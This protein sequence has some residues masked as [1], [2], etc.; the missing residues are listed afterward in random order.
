MDSKNANAAAAAPQAKNRL[1][2]LLL[3]AVSPALLPAAGLVA[4]LALMPR[5]GVSVVAAGGLVALGLALASRAGLVIATTAMGLLCAGLAPPSEPRFESW[6]P[7]EVVGVVRSHPA[8]HDERT[9]L[10]VQVSR[11]RQGLSVSG[12]TFDL[13]ASLPL[14]LPAPPIGTTVRLRGY[15]RRSAGY[16]NLV[17][18]DPGPW[19]L[20]LKSERFLSAE[21]PPKG[22]AALAGALRRRAEAVLTEHD[23]GRPGLRLLRAL[24]FGDR[25]ALPKAWQQA[26][27]RSGLA[28]IL[29]VSGLHVGL[30]AAALVLAGALLPDRWRWLPAVLGL[31]VYGLLVGP[32]PAVLRASI[33]GLLM[34][35]ALRCH[36]PPQTLNALAACVAL[37]VLQDPSIV[38]RLG[39]QL[40]VAAT[41]GI[42]LLA[43]ALDRRWVWLPA[44]VRQPL[45]VTVAAQLATAPWILPL[46]GGIQGVA[47]LANLLA[48]PYLV[49]FLA[50]AFVWLGVAS[51]CPSA[52]AT[53][54]PLLDAA[55]QPVAALAALP[56]GYA[57]FLPLGVA[58]PGALFGAAVG[59]TACLW[60]RLAGRC[61]T[62]CW[63]AILT[64]SGDSTQPRL[65]SPEIALIDVGQGDATLLRDGSRAVLVDGGGWRYGDLGGRVVLP[66]LAALGVRQLDAVVATHPD[67]DH[68][69]GLV[70]VARYMPVG[71]VWVGP[72]WVEDRCAAELLTLPRLRWRVLWRGEEERVGRW[73][74]RVLH[75][76]AGQRRARNDRSLV[77]FAELDRY[78]LWLTGDIEASG[79]RQLARDLAADRSRVSPIDRQRGPRVDILKVA[80]HG[81]KTST[82][83]A[84]LRRVRPQLA[85]ISAGPGN[86]YGHPHRRTLRRLEAHGVKVLRTDLSGMVR[87]KLRAS[88][89]AIELP[90]SPRLIA[91]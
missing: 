70:D 40:S 56:P 54:L 3:P 84:F 86:L 11:L 35:A 61:L 55:T 51:V 36:R 15:L 1:A 10:W 23:P 64:G 17:R 8:R 32:R 38:A 50:S 19:R 77:I 90:G 37:M 25:S 66:A 65:P 45:A 78:R 29:A 7:V 83:E 39:F 46:T 12:V 43:P 31:I 82:T 2:R 41:A 89:L 75:P 13:A 44:L 60:P 85:L 47:P 49:V 53:L 73:R 24:V 22:L 14:A 68:C 67:R 4:G 63:L 87:L 16:A 5:G 27:Q 42:L 79:E 28:H 59:L 80:H 91:E 48:V 57:T 33:M 88:H 26:L 58:G 20:Y 71:E 52:A 9:Q 72:G 81:S 62:V 69:A 30:L 18:R 21:T 6:R 34:I 76:R 74:L